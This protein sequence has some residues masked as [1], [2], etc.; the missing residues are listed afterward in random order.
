LL[1]TKH[2]ISRALA[3]RLAATGIETISLSVDTLDPDLSRELIGSGAYPEQVA[4]SVTNLRRAGLSFAIQAVLTPQTLA[5]MEE[6][7]AF[8]E[9]EEG[10]ALQLVPFEPVRRPI[11]PIDQSSLLV[12]RGD[13]LHAFESIKRAHP[14]L[15]VTLFEKARADACD[16]LHCD[17]GGTKLF[18]T[19]AG[20]VHRCYKLTEDES[21]FGLDLSAHGIAAAWHDPVFATKLVPEPSAYLDTPCNTCGAAKR[22]NASG[23]C[24]FQA[25]L[26]YGKYAAPD[27]PCAPSK[28]W[29]EGRRLRAGDNGGQTA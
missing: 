3:E 1:T 21:L 7:A 17:I 2:P 24:I 4:R 16:E 11:R 6:V 18:F 8:V 19:P 25:Q 29:A 13:A 26:D 27:R 20:R 14:T 12:S 9:R 5:Q 22:C 23:R 15:N 10:A 28:T